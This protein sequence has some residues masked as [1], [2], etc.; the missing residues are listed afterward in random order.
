LL[1]KDCV[2]WGNTE[3][4][5]QATGISGHLLIIAQKVTPIF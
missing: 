2:P 1:I 4:L 3:I 5:W